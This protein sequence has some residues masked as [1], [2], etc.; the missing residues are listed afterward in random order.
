MSSSIKNLSCI[1]MSIF[2]LFIQPISLA[3]ADDLTYLLESKIGKETFYH[4]SYR[5]REFNK[6]LRETDWYNENKISERIQK[7][8]KF[9]S[10][11]NTILF[12]TEQ[13]YC[14]DS[15][16][17]EAK[18][19]LLDNFHE[20]VELC[21]YFLELQKQLIKGMDLFNIINDIKA[22]QPVLKNILQSPEL[23]KMITTQEK[24]I[25]RD[26]SITERQIRSSME[27]YLN[28]DRKDFDKLKE[29]NNKELDKEKAKQINN[30]NEMIKYVE[31]YG[32]IVFGSVTIAVNSALAGTG[33]SLISAALGSAG[34][35]TGMSLLF[36]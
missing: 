13:S 19:I 21:H 22:T 23:R 35:S 4:H 25:L 9:L 14:M 31:G 29:L 12:W 15:A 2:F 10:L 36:N 16:K 20:F 26:L 3:C 7:G 5:L 1:I 33:I 24:N 28:M 30:H 8:V 32:L 6:W 27:M 34:I 18:E 11:Y 17:K